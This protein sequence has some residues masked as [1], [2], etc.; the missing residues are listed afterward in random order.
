MNLGSKTARRYFR[1]DQRF[2]TILLRSP[3]EAVSRLFLGVAPATVLKRI[4]PVHVQPVQRLALGPDAHIA[5]EC[6]KALPPLVAYA[7]SPTA[8]IL[9]LLVVRIRAS[10]DHVAPGVVCLFDT[11]P[12]MLA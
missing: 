10:L 5:D 7:D 6:Q 1:S 9:V 12:V 2:M 4:R 3:T 11:R 8:I